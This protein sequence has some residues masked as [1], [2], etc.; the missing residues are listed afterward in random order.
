MS[1]LTHRLSGPVALAAVAIAMLVWTWGR[2]CDAIVDFGREIYVAWRLSAGDVLYRDIDYFNGPVSPYLNA[3]IFRV[4]GSSLLALEIANLLWWTLL[5]VMAYRL[6]V[7]MSDRLSA[8]VA[9]VL[10]IALFSFLQLTGIGNYNFVTPYAHE[11]THALLCA[12]GV[13]SLLR[14]YLNGCDPGKERGLLGLCG[15]LLGFIFLMKVEVTIAIGAALA[16][17]VSLHLV[18]VRARPACWF[19]TTALIAGAAVIPLIITFVLLRVEMPTGQAVRGLLGSWKYL[20]DQRIAGNDFYRHL[21]GIDKPKDRIVSM[22]WMLGGELA[23]LV[24]PAVLAMSIREKVTDETRWFSAACAAGYA[25]VIVWIFWDRADWQGAVQP[26][27]VIVTGIILA[28]AAVALRQRSRIWPRWILQMSFSVF[29]IGLLGKIFLNVVIYHYGFALTAPAFA[30]VVMLLVGWIPAAIK[31]SGGTAWVFRAAVLTVLGSLCLRY[32]IA[33]QTLYRSQTPASV[34]RGADEF[35]VYRDADT[36]NAILNTLS[37]APSHQTLATVPQG[38]MINYL[39]RRI[40]PTGELTLLPGEVDMFGE[41]R[42]L[43]GFQ[44]HPPDWI[45]AV[46]TDVSEFGSSGF[47]VDYAKRVSQ[48]IRKNYDA[49]PPINRQSKFRLMKFDPGHA[50]EKERPN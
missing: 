29:S 17:G 26:L 7:A 34:G 22:L 39:S 1:W 16:V 27:N 33:Y 49:L 43:D 48:F 42:I 18:L 4:F 8:F 47:G 14:V 36:I 24:P 40:N 19:K 23:L 35:A 46:Q 10:F 38:A 12:F 44:T 41:D 50:F 5:C 31:R 32:L 11:M 21:M 3:L 25:A 9:M 45:V 28:L 30:L 13:L 2:Y 37:R 20:R 6:Y 15:L